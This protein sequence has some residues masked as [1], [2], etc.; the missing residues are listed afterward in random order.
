MFIKIPYRSSVNGQVST[1]WTCPLNA[2]ILVH[3]LA[4]RYTIKWIGD[5]ADKLADWDLT[6]EDYDN[7][8]AAIKKSN[9]LEA[10][11]INAKAGKEI[12][13]PKFVNA[14]MGLEV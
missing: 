6:K 5:Y 11:D 10:A 3:S 9:M 1:Y 7:I 2:F 8:E 14:I 12:V 4:G 13:N